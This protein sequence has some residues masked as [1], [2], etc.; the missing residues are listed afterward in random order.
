MMENKTAAQR[1]VIAAMFAALACVAT[2]IIKIPSPMKGYLNLGDCIVL[3]AGWMLSPVYGFMAAGLGSALAD[4][5]SGYLVY[6]PATFFI[7][8][9]MAL[10]AHFGYK[11]FKGK[12]GTLIS[13]VLSGTAAELIMILGY[14]AFESVLYGFG[15]SL[16]NVPANGVQGVAGLLLGCA[17]AKIFEKAKI[18]TPK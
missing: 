15:P 4:L 8:G 2:I 5:L 6:A 16:V 13:R 17:L 9:A 18:S 12:T 11:L 3:L 10:A 7:K 14:L 1:V